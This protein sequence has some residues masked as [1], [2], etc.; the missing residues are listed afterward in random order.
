MNTLIEKCFHT[1]VFTAFFFTLAYV[2]DTLA[3]SKPVE[4]YE[5]YG[6]YTDT[7]WFITSFFAIVFVGMLF[8][9]IASKYGPFKHMALAAN[10]S[11]VMLGYAINGMGLL[12]IVYFLSQYIV[13]P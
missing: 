8:I 4:I 5:L 1:L 7:L 11:N 12:C 6:S 10:K 9:A 13:F 2:L 3:P